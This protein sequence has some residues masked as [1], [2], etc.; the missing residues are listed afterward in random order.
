MKPSTPQPDSMEERLIYLVDGHHDLKNKQDITACVAQWSKIMLA[1]RSEIN[2]AERAAEERVLRDILNLI[3]ETEEGYL[4][5]NAHPGD[6]AVIKSSLDS[7]K[8][9]MNT[10]KNLILSLGSSKGITL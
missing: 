3:K 5:Q 2:H 1:I 6:S 4:I 10:V 9:T 8:I 7:R